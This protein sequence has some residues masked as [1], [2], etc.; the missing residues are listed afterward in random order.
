M[1]RWARLL[2]MFRR[3][4]AARKHPLRPRKVCSWCTVAGRP[5]GLEEGDPG[6]LVSHGI[7][8]PCR[9]EQLRAYEAERL[10]QPRPTVLSEQESLAAAR[11]HIAGRH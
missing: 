10:E 6:A 9:T 1:I 5:A 3:R 2:D 8:G 7:C 4:M 11:L